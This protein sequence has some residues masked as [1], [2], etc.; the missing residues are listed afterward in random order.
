M[1][2][3]KLSFFALFLL[4][5]ASISTSCGGG[6]AEV[7]AAAGRLLIRGPLLLAGK[8][9]LLGSVYLMELFGL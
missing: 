2:K 4:S 5:F 7:A 3:D 6:G 1:R 9:A 8:S